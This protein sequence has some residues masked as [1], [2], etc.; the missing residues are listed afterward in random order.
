MLKDCPQHQWIQSRNHETRVV[1]RLRQAQEAS[2][3]TD[4]RRTFSIDGDI[5]RE[6][7]LLPS[8]ALQHVMSFLRMDDRFKLLCTNKSW[9]AHEPIAT[10]FASFCGSC[11]H[12]LAN[13]QHLCTKGYN[14]RPAPF[15]KSLLVHSHGAMR[16]LRLA[17]CDGFTTKALL[18]AVDFTGLRVLDLNRCSSIGPQEVVLN[19][20]IGLCMQHLPSHAIAFSLLTWGRCSC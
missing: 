10:S 9:L 3:A 13:A 14:Q 5:T 12:C 7:T 8:D 15:W 16:A 18:A 1:L 20:L 2:A 19:G 6:S 11:S 17:N 4:D